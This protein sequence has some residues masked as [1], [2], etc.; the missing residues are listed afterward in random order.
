MSTPSPPSTSSLSAQLSQSDRHITS[1]SLHPPLSRHIHGYQPEPLQMCYPKEWRVQA[2]HLELKLRH[3][4]LAFPPIFAWVV[5]TCSGSGQASSSL[6]YSVWSQIEVRVRSQC[7]SKQYAQLALH[8]IRHLRWYPPVAGLHWLRPLS[9]ERASQ[10]SASLS[11]MFSLSRTSYN[12]DFPR[13]A[14][15][16]AHLELILRHSYLALPST[17]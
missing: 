12:C 4:Y 3:S 10:M 9:P 11:V 5:R 15:Q 6:A 7:E 1:G 8:N 16:A 14:C 17:L 13:M 2:V